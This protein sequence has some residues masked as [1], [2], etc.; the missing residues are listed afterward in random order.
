MA[1]SSFLFVL[2]SLLQT[3]TPSSST[4]FDVLERGASLSEKTNDTL[5]SPNG[6]FSAGFL[7]VGDNAFGFAIWYTN[8]LLNDHTVV[9]MANREEPAGK[10]S[11]HSLLKNGDLV[12]KEAGR[13]VLWSTGTAS[14]SSMKLELLNTGNLVLSTS[15]GVNCLWQSFDSPTDTLLPQQDPNITSTYWPPIW[16]L[17]NEA[18]RNRYNSSRTAVLDPSGY[19][20]S[21]DGLEFSSTDFGEGPLRRL[22]LDSD[23]N[24]RLYSFNEKTKKWVISW[25]AISK[26]CMVHGVC[27]PNGVCTYGRG[28]GRRCFCL[29]GYKVKKDS[30]WSSGCEPEFNFSCNHDD[31]GFLN[32]THVEFYGFSTEAISNL[33]FQGCKEKC[34]NICSCKGFQYRFH[35]EIGVYKCYPKIIL[36]NGHHTPSYGGVIY[37]KLPKD[38]SFLNKT[39]VKEIRLNC[40]GNISQSLK[41]HYGKFHGN[42]KVKF[43][44]WFASAIG[45]VEM[46]C[47]SL[48]WF[49]LFIANKNTKVVNRGYLLAARGFTKFTFDELKEA[50]KGFTEEIGR[51]AGGIVYRAL[52]F[53]NRVAAVKRLNE[54]TQGEAE[55]LTEVQTIEKL[56]HMYLIEM[57]GYCAEGKHRLLV[58]E[59]M[60]RGSLA[61]NL[62][63]NSISWDKRFEIAVGT[64]KGL[65]YL[66]DECLE[67]VL[68]C[69]IKPQNILLDSNYQPKVADFGLSKLR[70]RGGLN[71]SSFSKIRGTRGYMAPEWV[72]NLPITSKVDVYSYGI[73][74][75]EL[76]TGKSPAGAF[77]TYENEGM[78]EHGTLTTWVRE[79][80]N[81][82]A[83]NEAWIKEIVDPMIAGNCDINKMKI[84]V[85]VALQCVEEDR[86]A[87]PSMS[88]VVEMLLS[89]EDDDQSPCA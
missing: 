77:Q 65:S 70:S 23:G 22:T 88:E 75:L 31:F 10:K 83:S 80:K 73:V 30:D 62:H 40:S 78:K 87:R 48:V 41:R 56:N 61:D 21:S 47:I 69:D 15:D 33:T 71:D 72:Y 49:F 27:G 63:S 16:L 42:G 34:L 68:H 45:A 44:L 6:V 82:A 57:W 3:W 76:V 84:M 55:F 81:I 26:A 20:I 50:T 58:Y 66:H 79:K 39:T 19:F 24:L 29:P 12:L 11:K 59:Y 38:S 53:D 46:T 35:N 25:Q 13:K 1:I 4:S 14:Q 86:A 85:Q 7:S 51:G 36:F 60:A 9:W 54:A 18:G 32:F 28:L 52:L 67:W 74:L 64:A 43:L 17:P 2:L 89:F 8:I 5:I 37:L